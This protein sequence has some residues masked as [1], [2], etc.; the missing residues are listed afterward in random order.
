MPGRDELLERLVNEPGF[1]AVL[2]ADP[3]SA[4]A[5]YDLDADD[6]VVVTAALTSGA[7]VSGAV[8]HRQSKSTLGGM[9]AGLGDLLAG[10]GGPK[11]G[12]VGPD[13]DGDGLGDAAEAAHGTNPDVADSDWD[14]LSD[15]DEVLVHGT[16]PLSSDTDGDQI[17]DSLELG[18]YGTDPLSK[19]TDGDHLSDYKEVW[20]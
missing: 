2:T 13:S 1:R 17:P 3:R 14:G 8:E 15:G 11:V 12:D 18:K 5:E 16:N 10:G 19:D 20:L 9:L 7:G 4:L 6:L